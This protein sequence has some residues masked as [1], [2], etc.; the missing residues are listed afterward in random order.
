ME[1]AAAIP[2]AKQCEFGKRMLPP[3]S[4]RTDEV[5]RHAQDHLRRLCHADGLRRALHS[6]VLGWGGAEGEQRAMQELDRL[7][8]M[9]G[10]EAQREAGVA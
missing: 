4:Q 10:V 7:E 1:T 9:E 6:A 5:Y 2:R 8:A 3:W